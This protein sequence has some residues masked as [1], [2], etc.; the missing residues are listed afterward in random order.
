MPRH[1][2]AGKPR[3]VQKLTG[4]LHA[5]HLFQFPDDA[6]AQM[7]TGHGLQRKGVR[8]FRRVVAAVGR[9]AERERG[10]PPLLWRK[11]T[12]KRLPQRLAVVV[13]QSH[14]RHFSPSAQMKAERLTKAVGSEDRRPAHQERGGKRG[15]TR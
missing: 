4:F 8:V 5:R 3:P 15:K 11:D 13:D 12:I 10:C 7:G 2:A 6:H 9:L 14:A 1:E